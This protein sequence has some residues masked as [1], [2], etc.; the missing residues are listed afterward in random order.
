MIVRLQLNWVKLNL[1]REHGVSLQA[2]KKINH[3]MKATVIN[4]FQQINFKN[5]KT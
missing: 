4:N 1:K 5:M 3:K 2:L